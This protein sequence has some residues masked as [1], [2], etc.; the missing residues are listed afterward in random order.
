MQ[1]TPTEHTHPMSGDYVRITY[2]SP[3]DPAATLKVGDLVTLTDASPCDAGFRYAPSA[4][5]LWLLGAQVDGRRRSVF[6]KCEI[7]SRWMTDAQLAVFQD[8]EH[9]TLFANELV[10]VY[11][12]HREQQCPTVVA[13][14]QDTRDTLPPG[15]ADEGALDFERNVY[16]HGEQDAR[17]TNIASDWRPVPVVPSFADVGPDSFPGTDEQSHFVSRAVSVSEDADEQAD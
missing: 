10:R 15:P 17:L 14:E 11:R 3:A 4:P 8:D 6:G 13:P 7:V 16:T 5:A 12:I 1:S 9:W 2:I